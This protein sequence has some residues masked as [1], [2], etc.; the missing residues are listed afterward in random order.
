[1]P[2]IIDR[3]SGRNN[4]VKNSSAGKEEDAGSHCCLAVAM[5]P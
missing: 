4:S 3:C 1:L 5:L 2:F